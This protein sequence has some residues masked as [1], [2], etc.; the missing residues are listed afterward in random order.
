MI[1]HGNLAPEG[2][3]AKIS[4]KEGERFSGTAIVF[5][6]EEAALDGDSRAAASRKA[7]SW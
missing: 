3:V 4:G 7:T 2:A 5:D 6:R 1:L